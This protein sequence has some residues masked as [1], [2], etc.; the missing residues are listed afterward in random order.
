VGCQQGHPRPNGKTAHSAS[1]GARKALMEAFRKQ[2]DGIPAF[3]TKSFNELTKQEYAEHWKRFV[4]RS[5]QAE[6]ELHKVFED[7]KFS[8]P[9]ASTRSPLLRPA[10]YLPLPLFR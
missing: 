1:Y 5:E 2:L 6:A 4:D 10:R 7:I 8:T 3:Q 9:P